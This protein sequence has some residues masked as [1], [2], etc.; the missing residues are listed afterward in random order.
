MNIAET[1][2][3][4]IEWAKSRWRRR[5]EE[6]QIDIN[7]REFWV[8]KRKF[9]R[10]HLSVQMEG[11]LMVYLLRQG[12]IER[13]VISRM[14]SRLDHRVVRSRDLE[15]WAYQLMILSPHFKKNWKPLIAMFCVPLGDVALNVICNK[16]G[17]TKHRGSIY[18][19]TL[20]DNLLVFQHS[21]QVL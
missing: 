2:N 6:T 10:D 14:L 16:D 17:I 15:N 11:F 20:R 9:N 8:N 21:I 13:I 12:L 4:L 1:S 19:S 7:R 3:G 18:Q 5:S